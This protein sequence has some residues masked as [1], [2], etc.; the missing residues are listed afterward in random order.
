MA[1][2]HLQNS[3]LKNISLWNGFYSKHLLLLLHC[4]AQVFMIKA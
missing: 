2:L 3:S 4:Y 1:K